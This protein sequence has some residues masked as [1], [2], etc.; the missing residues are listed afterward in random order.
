[1]RAI[2]PFGLEASRTYAPFR[3]SVVDTATFT[4]TPAIY[5]DFALVRIE[6][7]RVLRTTPTVTVTWP[8]ARSDTLAVRQIDL[9]S[10]EVIVP[11]DSTVSGDVTVTVFGTL[12]DIGRRDPL[13]IPQTGEE[14]GIV[15]SVVFGRRTLTLTQQTVTASGGSV[16]SPDGM[17][18]ARFPPNRVYAPLF[19]RAEAV[20]AEGRPD[21]PLVGAAYRFTPDDVPFDGRAELILR[22]SAGFDRPGRLGVYRRSED[23]AWRFVD[24]R[25][26]AKAGT[27]SAEVSA[28]S[29]FGLLADETPPVIADLKP[30]R[31][32]KVA[33]RRP[34]L[35]AIIRDAGAGIWREE[36]IALAL[37]GK[38]LISEYDPDK[39]TVTARP[40]RPLRPGRHRLEVRVR[41]I[42]GNEARAVS[43]FVIR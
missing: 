18:E 1:M 22:Y 27:V 8:N 28:F 24:H 19:A 40:K 23:G 26:D 25:V 16:R 14:W 39:E 5:P 41:D 6:T 9:R 7:D 12:P 36:D 11:F 34:L 33:D 29:T 21:L 31:G 20:R 38:R 43:A 30:A 3:I 10:Y 15:P 42:C 13:L 32:A 2:D 37:D 35:S 4:C 17:A